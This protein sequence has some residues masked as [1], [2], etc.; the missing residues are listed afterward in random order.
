MLQAVYLTGWELIRL[1]IFLVGIHATPPTL[2]FPSGY[3]EYRTYL[4][5]ALEAGWDRS[6]KVAIFT[7]SFYTFD[8]EKPQGSF[9]QHWH[10]VHIPLFLYP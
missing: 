9:Q 2:P 10:Q 5:R 7:A 6:A 4:S 1:L 3:H 8:T